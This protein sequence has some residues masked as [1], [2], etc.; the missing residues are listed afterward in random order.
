MYFYI[1]LKPL[2]NTSSF[3]PHFPNILRMSRGVISIYDDY[4]VCYVKTNINVTEILWHFKII[5]NW[6]VISSLILKRQYYLWYFKQ[7]NN[8]TS[9]TSTRNKQVFV[10]IHHNYLIQLSSQSHLH[11]YTSIIIGTIWKIYKYTCIHL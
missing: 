6:S 8:Y 4:F 11:I 7:D 9:V 3:F 10:A 1:W 5:N 2:K